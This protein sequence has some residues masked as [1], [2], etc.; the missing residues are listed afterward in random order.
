M[1]GW[2]SD[3]IFTPCES[4]SS[5]QV[6]RFHLFT[7]GFLLKRYHEI[8][9]LP[10]AI[11][12]KGDKPEYE[13]EHREA[14]DACI[15]PSVLYLFIRLPIESK[16]YT[17]LSC[18]AKTTFPFLVRHGDEYKLDLVLYLEINVTC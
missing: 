16:K 18:P 8:G 14:N 15:Q 9:S 17:Y 13:I 12:G 5:N 10:I 11:L 3:P 4:L 1:I 6:V 2:E 7:V